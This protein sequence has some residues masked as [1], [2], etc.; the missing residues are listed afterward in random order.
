[1]RKILSVFLTLTLLMALS[2]GSAFAKPGNGASVGK[3]KGFTDIEGHWGKASIMKVQAKGLFN[4]YEDGSFRPDNTITQ[5]EVAVL[6]DR[7]LAYRL[8]NESDDRILTD[9]DDDLIGVPEWAKK[10]VQ[11]GAKKKYLNLK[12]FHSQVQCDRLT[13]S[14]QL[15]KALGLDPVNDQ[16]INPFK[17]RG[18]ISDEDYG[19]LLALYKAGYITGYPDGNF[20]PNGFIRR[21]EMASI[22]ANLLGNDD[23]DV[24][25]KTAPS[26]SSNSDLSATNISSTHVYLSWTAASD[27][28]KV[29]G[30]KII[31]SF[32]GDEKEKYVSLTRSTTI[33]GL[34][35][36]EEYD[37]TVEARDAAGNW[38][39][40]GP[41]VNVTTKESSYTEDYTVP[42]WSDEF[43]SARNITSSSVTL[44]WSGADDNV[45]VT[46]YR[47]YVDGVLKYTVNDYVLTKTITGLDEDT[48]YTF[49]VEAGDADGNWSDDGPEV[50]VTTRES[51]DTTKPYWDDE[52]LTVT[53]I[54]DTS[55]TLKWLGAEDNEAVTQYKVYVNGSLRTTINDG[56]A[57]TKT[58]TGLND[59][60][61]Y[62][63]RVQAG[64]EAG[65]WS[66]DGPSIVISTQD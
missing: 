44:K 29:S 14:V 51:S 4:G 65:N 15:A 21:A 9:D 27:N 64:D 34:E 63:F 30:Y 46:K 52:S 12:R 11:K 61:N 5:A 2:V 43:L 19:Y 31:Y 1:M 25:D 16:S 50:D 8:N 32:N 36:D 41:S 23:E 10:A 20:N 66:T 47:I 55:V 3:A 40:D 18:L 17:D 39:D 57:S 56:N 37:F 35:P 22:I 60:S 59:G 49:R 54:T 58:I 62:T 38:S 45:E 6:A 53:N 24:Y 13:A 26:W 28:E 48:E 33:S 42:N 7:L